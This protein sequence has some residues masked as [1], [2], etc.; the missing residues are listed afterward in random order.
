VGEKTW[1]RVRMQPDDGSVIVWASSGPK[2]NRWYE[3]EMGQ[4]EETDTIFVPSNEIDG[5]IKRLKLAQQLFKDLG[6][7]G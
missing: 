2:P 1:F 7:G 6:L 3:V 4:R 5:L